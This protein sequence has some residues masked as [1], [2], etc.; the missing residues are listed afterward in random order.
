V[1]PLLQDIIVGLVALGAAVYVLRRVLETV[2]PEP[3]REG[4][5]HCGLQGDA[6]HSEEPH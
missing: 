6:G 2:R 3:A 5:E 4:C 1:T